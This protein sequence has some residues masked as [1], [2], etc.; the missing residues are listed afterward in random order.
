[1][2]ISNDINTIII[3][4]IA[5]SLASLTPRNDIARLRLKIQISKVD[6]NRL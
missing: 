5:S 3:H 4:K 2:I 6:V 1:M